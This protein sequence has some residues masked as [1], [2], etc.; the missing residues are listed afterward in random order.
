M[1]YRQHIFYKKQI[2][3][4]INEFIFCGI[5]IIYQQTHHCSPHILSI[6]LVSFCFLPDD[7]YQ[8]LQYTH[9]C[10][11]NNYNYSIRI[12]PSLNIIFTEVLRKSLSL[13]LFIISFNVDLSMVWWVSTNNRKQSSD[14]LKIIDSMFKRFFM[15]RWHRTYH[16]EMHVALVSRPKEMKYVRHVTS[17]TEEPKPFLIFGEIQIIIPQ[18]D[19]VTDLY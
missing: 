2:P 9:L 11:A 3:S 19:K 18:P 8:A 14:S 4:I 10:T 15:C 12:T 5:Q 6:H 13:D 1:K 7:E 16:T 17:T